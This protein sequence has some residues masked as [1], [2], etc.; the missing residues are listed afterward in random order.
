MKGRRLA[1]AH[2][3]RGGKILQEGEVVRDNLKENDHGITSIEDIQRLLEK[4]N[5]VADRAIASAIYLSLSI[6]RPLLIEG[7]A[8]CGKTQIAKTLSEILGTDLIRL[9]CYEGLDANSALFEWDY[10]KQLLTIRMDENKKASQEIKKEI[11]GEDYLLKRPLLKALL[12]DGKTRPV[13][14]IDELDRADTEFEGFLLEFLDEFQITIPEYGTVKANKHPVV[15]ITSNRTREI[16]D[17]I[18]RR[19]L[20]LYL[21]YPDPERELRIINSKIPEASNE[22]ARQVVSFMEKVRKMEDI[23]KKP[24]VAETLDWIRALTM[25]KVARLNDEVVKATLGCVIKSPDDY[26]KMES[27]IIMKSLLPP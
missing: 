25:M 21:T 5:Y 14:L 20:Y 13:L 18:R 1:G 8:G 24:G 10:M 22:L 17:G 11:Y 12:Y 15:V 9:Q 2:L 4:S 27:Q 19:C 23:I 3:E 26:G 6:D 7:E 16:G